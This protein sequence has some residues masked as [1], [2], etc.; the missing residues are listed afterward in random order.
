MS[1]APFPVVPAETAPPAR[2]PRVVRFELSLKS[3]FIVLGLLAAV[4][5]LVHALPVLLVLVAALMLVGALNPLVAGLERR[6]L[7]RGFAIFLVF[8]LGTLVAAAL[9]MLTVPTVIRQVKSVAE[10]EPEIRAK[11]AGYLEQSRLT[12]SLAGGVRSARSVEQLK[13]S[14]RCGRE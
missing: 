5:L 9:F 13:S 10:H 7:W 1:A 3:L 4:W 12:A 2:P 11:I 14:Q 8:A 6:D